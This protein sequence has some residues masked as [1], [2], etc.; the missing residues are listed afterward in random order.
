MNCRKA[1]RFLFSYFKNELSE[2]EEAEIKLHLKGCPDCAR[3]SI[4][5]ERACLLIKDSLETLTPSPDFNQKLFFKI[6]KLSLEKVKE[7]KSPSKFS[8]LASH[9]PLRIR[10]ALA[11]SL[12]V[13]ILAS[14]LWFTHKPTPIKPE[15][16][17]KESK[18]TESFELVN[19]EDKEDSLYQEMLKRLV[20]RSRFATKTFVLDNFRRAGTRGIDGMEKPED[21][22]KSYIIETA[23]YGAEQ[24]RVE[25]HYVLPAVSIQQTSEKVNY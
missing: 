9:F 8:L 15:A 24:K 6:Q 19:K 25:N 16:I 5:V 7:V 21:M 17:S 1:R 13:I 2:K 22:Y 3:E 10:W 20:K 23:G 12:A 18:K 4:E 11:G 14:V